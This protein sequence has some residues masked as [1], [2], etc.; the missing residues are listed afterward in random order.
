M[1]QYIKEI[2]N[3]IYRFGYYSTEKTNLRLNT[4]RDIE[5]DAI[6]KFIPD[7]SLF[8]SIGCGSGYAMKRA[9]EEFNCNTIGIDPQPMEAGVKIDT[10]RNKNFKILKG[11]GEYLTFKDNCFDVVFSSHVLE[12]VSDAPKV[13]QEIKRVLKNDGVLIIGV[14]TATLALISLFSQ[15]IYTSHI[16]LGRYIAGFFT[17]VRKTKLIHIFIPYSH[18][19]INKT[20]LSDLINYKAKNWRKLI[21]QDFHISKELMPARYGFAEFKFPIGIRKN[22][23]YSSSVFF[24]CKIG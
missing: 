16:R 23:Q 22:P 3:R 6:K 1:K 10:K 17:K 11:V 19:N 13:L 4:I 9:I 24:I 14:P 2:I 12:H 21:N 7:N 5:W 18:S 20:V 8:L 15:L